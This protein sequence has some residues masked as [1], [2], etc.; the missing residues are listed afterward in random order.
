MVPRDGDE[1]GNRR[2][3]QVCSSRPLALEGGGLLRDVV[4]GYETLMGAVLELWNRT[5]VTPGSILP[6][7][8]DAYIERVV[9]DAP[10]HIV[11]VSEQRTFTGLLRR[12]VQVRDRECYHPK[13]DLPAVFSQVDHIL[14]DAL[15]G[16]T[17]QTNGRLACGHHNRLKETGYRPRRRPDGRYD[18][19]RP[20]GTTITPPA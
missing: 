13:C 12:A 14:P 18:L 7:L 9:F 16:P 2:F 4:V 20:D 15:G 19:L 6:W 11:E 5:M 17:T 10:G 8:T 3:T 1:P